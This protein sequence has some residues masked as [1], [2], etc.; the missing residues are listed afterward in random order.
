MNYLE[1]TRAVSLY[2]ENH[3]LVVTFDNFKELMAKVRSELDKFQTVAY[4][5]SQV[6]SIFRERLD[7]I[8]LRSF[9]ELLMVRDIFNNQV[10]SE[11]TLTLV[12]GCRRLLYHATKFLT[13]QT[14]GGIEKAELVDWLVSSRTI[15]SNSH[16]ASTLWS[17]ARDNYLDISVA[18]L[19]ADNELAMR[20]FHFC[21]GMGVSSA[22]VLSQSYSFG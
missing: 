14:I 4:E 17:K 8:V 16:K 18:A 5:W 15:L 7:D 19:L 12:A 6:V 11:D 13:V 2:A 10:I 21:M 3:A 22:T 20:Q 9:S 1:H